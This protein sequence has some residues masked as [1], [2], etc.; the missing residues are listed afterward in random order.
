[1]PTC[2]EYVVEELLGNL[3]GA[4]HAELGGGGVVLGGEEE[5]DGR[6]GHARVYEV[7]LAEPA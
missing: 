7:A 5:L 1:M 2:E 6:E 4:E 3:P